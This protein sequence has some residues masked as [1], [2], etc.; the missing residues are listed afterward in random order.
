MQIFT[1]HLWQTTEHLN[2]DKKQKGDV[3][4]LNELFRKI[5]FK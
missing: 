5:V 2:F 3:G 1:Q 4:V